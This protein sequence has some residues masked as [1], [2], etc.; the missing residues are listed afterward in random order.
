MATD[1]PDVPDEPRAEEPRAAA[2]RA[3]EP[4]VKDLLTRPAEVEDKLDAATL[5]ELAS[6]FS[7]PSIEALE[8]QAALRAAAAMPPE[9]DP[10]IIALQ[11][12]RQTAMAA[13]DPALVARLE[14]R[15]TTDIRHFHAYEPP[16]IIDETIVNVVVRDHLDRRF[17]EEPVADQRSYDQPPD[18]DDIV[19]GHNA[20]QAIL[21]DLYRPEASWDKR[22]ESPFDEV[23]TL[24]PQREIREALN[25]RYELEFPPSPFQ[26]G[27][28]ARA[29]VRA[30]MRESWA[31]HGETIRAFKKARGY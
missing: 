25:S 16:P 31:E 14:S 2:P 1:D 7:G 3:D 8:E 10:V 30:N 17:A 26:E 27:V 4:R 18:I 9:E 28:A 19:R 12:R 20:P 23:P 29:A 15:T 22:Y 6:W 5:N 24:D 11:A 21:R 13:A